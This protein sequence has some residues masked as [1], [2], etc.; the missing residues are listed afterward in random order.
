MMLFLVFSDWYNPGDVTIHLED[1][2][3]IKAVLLQETRDDIVVQI[4]KEERGNKGAALT[5]FISLAG[6]YLVMMPNNPRAGG[7]SRRIEGD[8]LGALLRWFWR[9]GRPARPLAGSAAASVSGGAPR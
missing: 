4:D 8:E 1:D 5:T 2:S 7:V 9:G 3:Q 6:R